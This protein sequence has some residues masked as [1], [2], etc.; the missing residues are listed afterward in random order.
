MKRP[1]K[2]LLS[3]LFYFSL[4]SCTE[5]INLELDD[6]YTRLIVDGT[7]TTDTTTHT[8]ILSKTS[9]YYYNKP[10]PMVTGAQLTITDGN[11]VF[12]LSE[13]SPGVYSTM[14]AVYGVPGKTYFLNIKLAEAIGGYSDYS[15]SSTIY[16]VNKLDSIGLRFNPDWSSAGIW[17]VKC[18]VQDPPTIDF[19]RFLISRNGR[20]VTDTLNEWIVSDDKFF[21]GNYANGATIAYLQQDSPDE[22]LKTGDLVTV[23]VN[24]IGKEYAEFL[25][26]AQSEL[27][28]SNPLFSGPPANVT[29]NINHGA[30]GFFAAYSLTRSSTRTPS[31]K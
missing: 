3:L 20:M 17:E 13:D 12:K 5:R 22:G 16:P 8:V 24:S 11:Q 6:S 19:Y 10:S 15:A 30:V 29:G 7:I 9:D 2:I 4:A 27:F 28:G 31:F 1:I 18:Y 26:A 25:W 21:N 23:E 14:P